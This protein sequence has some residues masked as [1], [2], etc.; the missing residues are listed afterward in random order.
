MDAVQIWNADPAPVAGPKRSPFRADLSRLRMGLARVRKSEPRPAASVAVVRSAL[1]VGGGIAGM[2][3]ALAI[4]DH[5]F[6]VVLVEK[7]GVLGGN[8][9]WIQR[10]ADGADPQALLAETVQ[11]V[12]KHPRIRVRCGSRVTASWGE[13]GRFT[14]A[15][16]D[17]EGA[18]E[19]IEH[20]VT[21]LATGGREAPTRSYGYGASARIVTH[22][23]LETKLA[24]GELDP[25]ALNSVVMIQCVDSREEPRNYC[26]RICCTAS[27]KHALHL[28]EKNPQVSIYVFYRDIMTYGFNEHYFTEARRAGV[29]FIPYDPAGKPQVAADGPGGDG[30][31]PVRVTAVDPIL[32]RPIEVEA[33]LIVLATGVVPELPS[34]LADAF[35]AATD[36][37]GFFAEAEFKWRPVDGLKEGVFACG[38]A[39]APRSIPE[40][41][42]TAGAAAERCLRMLSHEKLPGARVVATVRQSLCSLC[43]RCIETC[44]YHARS[45]GPDLDRV[46]VNAAM[47]QGCGDCATVCPNS[48]AVL[49]SFSDPQMLDVID[50]ALDRV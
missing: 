18:V 42:A 8:L 19:T 34:E 40:S 15:V 7:E 43:E 5:G 29:V 30:S 32:G 44:P 9:R 46:L 24:G 13:V 12:E 1:V 41:I 39:L 6:P 36:S 17:A 45:L 48:A 22:K 35:G 4:A 3:A 21:V 26:S 25:G 11:Q 20:G 27:M 2:T 37:D 14:T 33:D 38:L 28:K 47:C 31:G 23:E 50:A 16:E 49:L 10:T